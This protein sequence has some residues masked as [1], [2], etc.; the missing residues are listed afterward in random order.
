MTYEKPKPKR[1]RGIADQVS[2]ELILTTLALIITLTA[3]SMAGQRDDF[4][5]AD[6]AG[7]LSLY[8]VFLVGL[9]LALLARWRWLPRLVAFALI[10]L[11]SA[12]WIL[13]SNMAALDPVIGTLF[14]PLFV[15]LGAV[16]QP[17][18][19][20]GL[21][22]LSCAMIPLCFWRVWWHGL[23]GQQRAVRIATTI[24]LSACALLVYFYRMTLGG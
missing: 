11:L 20:V 4:P 21:A 9:L 12:A 13:S 24:L 5:D 2:A 6:L 1:K 3:V 17:A 10:A 8:G 23:N 18:F 7:A 14:R 15:L 16:P 19:V 22:L